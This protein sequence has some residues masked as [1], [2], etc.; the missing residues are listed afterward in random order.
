MAVTN[1]RPTLT[2]K[3]LLVLH[4]LIVLNRRSEPM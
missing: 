3:S 4:D 2:P 1:E